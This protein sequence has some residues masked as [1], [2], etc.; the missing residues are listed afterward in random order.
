MLSAWFEG[1]QNNI[2]E[3]RR[4]LQI[5]PESGDRLISLVRPIESRKDLRTGT[6]R[7]HKQIIPTV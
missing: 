4:Q 7:V 6:P 2:G 1:G 3:T 5:Y